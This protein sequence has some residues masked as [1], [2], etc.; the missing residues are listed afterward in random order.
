MTNERRQLHGYIY[1]KISHI[2]IKY[3]V[4]DDTSGYSTCKNKSKKKKDF[5]SNVR[6]IN[7]R[8]DW[9]YY[10]WKIKNK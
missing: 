6:R 2:H 9:I 7:S 3:V 4:T 1:I 5:L 10:M 8:L